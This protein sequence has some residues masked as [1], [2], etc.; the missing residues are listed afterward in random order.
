[1]NVLDRLVSVFAPEAGLRRVWA[2]NMLDRQ[3]NY[4]AAESGRRNKG[5]KGRSTSANVEVAS[6]LHRLRDRAREFARDNW[7]AQR[8]LDVLSAHVV[9][10]GISIV[11]NTGSDPADRRFREAWEEW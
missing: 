7:A 5:W 11:P 2:R 4:A 6:G 10:T 3:R 9:G 1:M 8:I